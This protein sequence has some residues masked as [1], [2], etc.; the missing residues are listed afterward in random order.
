MVLGIKRGA[1]MGL[2]SVYGNPASAP[3]TAANT[4]ASSVKSSSKNARPAPKRTLSES[5][6]RAKI[7]QL[8]GGRAGN[9][10]QIS[11]KA[12]ALNKKSHALKATIRGEDHPP[13]DV[14]ANNPNDPLT[15][16]KLKS[17]LGGGGFDFNP[18]ER[19]A[20]EKIL[21]K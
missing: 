8:Q 13:G 18:K 5:E 3:S 16:H 21:A 10:A 12:Q 20:L 9:T 14:A 17:L 6:V 7:K 2:F 1:H 19:L 15:H 11:N 4:K